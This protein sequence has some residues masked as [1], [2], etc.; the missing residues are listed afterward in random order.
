[1]PEAYAVLVPT[2]RTHPFA[3]SLLLTPVEDAPLHCAYAACSEAATD[4]QPE[5]ALM[6]FLSAGAPASVVGVEQRWRL[7]RLDG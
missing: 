7:E 1:V 5:A 6:R 3:V 4:E 2:P